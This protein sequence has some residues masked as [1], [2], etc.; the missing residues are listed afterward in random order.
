MDHLGKVSQVWTFHVS[1]F[2]AT[3]LL[4]VALLVSFSLGYPVQL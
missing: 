2:A 3:E 1:S 4:L